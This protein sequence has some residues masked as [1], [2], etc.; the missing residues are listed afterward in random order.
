[1]HG[2]CVQRLP[3]LILSGWAQVVTHVHSQPGT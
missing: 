2:I 3:Y 1:M